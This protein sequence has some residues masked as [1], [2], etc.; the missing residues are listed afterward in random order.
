METKS[1]IDDIVVEKKTR[2]P[3]L[4]KIVDKAVLLKQLSDINL[5]S[6][7]P[8]VPEIP[9]LVRKKSV[10]H[11]TPPITPPV[12]PVPVSPVPVLH[13]SE[14]DTTPC[15]TTPCETTPCGTVVKTVYRCE[16]CSVAF[17]SKTLFE[18]HPRTIKHKTNEVKARDD[19][20]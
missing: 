10:K 1:I 13:V 4:S 19:K 15:G 9:K 3:R 2:K 16:L 8:I 7:D 12:S 17:T 20:K 6:S 5:T 14:E 18:R 11:V